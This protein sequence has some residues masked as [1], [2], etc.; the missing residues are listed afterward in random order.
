VPSHVSFNSARIHL[1]AASGSIILIANVNTAVDLFFAGAPEA[2]RPS[3]VLSRLAPDEIVGGHCCGVGLRAKQESASKEKKEEG[4]G[5]GQNLPSPHAVPSRPIAAWV[6][7]GERRRSP[8]ILATAAA[9]MVLPIR[10]LL[11][12]FPGRSQARYGFGP[13]PDNLPPVR[14]DAN[15]RPTRLVEAICGRECRETPPTSVHGEFVSTGPP[16]KQAPFIFSRRTTR[17][18]FLPRRLQGVRGPMLCCP[19]F[20]PGQTRRNAR[21]HLSRGG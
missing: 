2:G 11:P 5:G 17:G 15:R 1:A 6:T 10:L 16:Q 21:Q 14:R 20:G 8:R 19:R 3:P 18:C 4:A 13:F 7:S 12:A 9:R